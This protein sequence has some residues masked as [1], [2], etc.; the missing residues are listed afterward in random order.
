MS[1]EA[2]ASE[3]TRQVAGL[4]GRF[5]EVQLAYASFR[6]AADIIRSC[7]A[8]GPA[9]ERY[10]AD[11]LGQLHR[12]GVL[13]YDGA[14]VFEQDDPLT[15]RSA[16]E[17]FNLAVRQARLLAQAVAADK[18]YRALGLPSQ[19]DLLRGGNTGR[20]AATGASWFEQRS[21]W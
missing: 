3:V 13:G 10:A 2:W 16:A 21:L 14:P 1:V 19:V 20:V 11:V 18:E 6:D 4:L 12:E 7:G 5:V 15:L 17:T 9:W 8:R